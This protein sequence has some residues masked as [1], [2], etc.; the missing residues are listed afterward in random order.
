MIALSRAY[1]PPLINALQ[2]GAERFGSRG[3]RRFESRSRLRPIIAF[4]PLPSGLVLARELA[5]TCEDFRR[6][7]R[8][9]VMDEV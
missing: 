6:D 2:Q 7:L 8:Q 9:L 5:A 4:D 3:D 1:P